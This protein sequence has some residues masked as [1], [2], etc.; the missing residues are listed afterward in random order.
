M[1]NA[2]NSH[3]PSRRARVWRVLGRVLAS[4]VVLVLVA[5]GTVFGLSQR[6]LRVSHDVPDHPFVV[7]SDSITVARGQHLTTIRGCIDCHDTDFGGKM[8]LDDPAIGRIGGA[9]L[10][11]GRAGG[12]LTDLDWERAVRHGVRRDGRALVFMPSEE[13]AGFSDEDLSAI[14]AYVRSLPPVSRPPLPVAMGPVLRAMAAAG[15]VK[16]SVEEINHTAAHPASVP[17]EPT[18][19]YGKYLAQGCTGC[20]GTG[21][22]GGKIP[23]APPDW[24]PAANITP[25]G[26]GRYSLE[27]FTRI[28]QTGRRPDGSAVDSLMPWKLTRHMTETEVR[29]LYAYLRTVPPRDFGNR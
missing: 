5:T 1:S 13:F 18:P 23:A 15:V 2:Q 29:A 20:H 24:K 11:S 28:L 9:N 16:P 27:D 17:A 10:T 26:I 22:S 4:V 25:T 3:R 14:A 12:A 8:V 19:A 21:F 6:M 7:H